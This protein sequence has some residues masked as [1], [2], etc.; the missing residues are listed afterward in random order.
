M[1]PVAASTTKTTTTTSAQLTKALKLTKLKKQLAAL[2]I[3]GKELTLKLK[4]TSKHSVK[5]HSLA[6]QIA[7]VTSREAKLATEIAV[8]EK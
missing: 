5:H 4:A 2:K 7:S 8:L 6:K 1:I 3:T